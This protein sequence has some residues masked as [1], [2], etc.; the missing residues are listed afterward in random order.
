MNKRIN[1]AFAKVDLSYVQTITDSFCAGAETIPDRVLF[2]H[3]NG[4]GGAISVTERSCTASISNVGRH[5]PDR[6]CSRL[7]CSVNGYSAYSGSE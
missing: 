1:V 5:I 3:N 6:F 7:W 2:T 4:C